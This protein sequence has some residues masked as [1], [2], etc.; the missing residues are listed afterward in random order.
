MLFL[1]GKQLIQAAAQAKHL[2]VLFKQH[3]E[4]EGLEGQGVSGVG[5]GS[6]VLVGSSEKLIQSKLVATAQGAAE[7]GERLLLLQEGDGD[8]GESAAHVW[9]ILF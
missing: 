2:L 8:G 6:Q 9:I 1:G 5:G 4:Q 3:G 7:A